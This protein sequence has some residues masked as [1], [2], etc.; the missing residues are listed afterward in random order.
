MPAAIA[1]EPNS[2]P[3]GQKSREKAL[4]SDCARQIEAAVDQ[5]LSAAKPTTDAMFDS[6][7]AEPTPS[8]I[9]QREMAR[10]YAGEHGH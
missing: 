9:E 5:Y 4:Q 2:M 6:L 3:P 1:H 7:F 10:R 8:L